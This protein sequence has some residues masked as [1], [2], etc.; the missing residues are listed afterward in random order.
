MKTPSLTSELQ[1]FFTQ[2]L[3]EMDVIDKEKYGFF[4][5]D[6]DEVNAFALS[7]YKIVVNRGLLHALDDRELTSFSHMKSRISRSGIMKERPPWN[8]QKFP[9]SRSLTK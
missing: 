7:H 8:I 3:L 6:D 2:L 4:V 1:R 5:S 9:Y